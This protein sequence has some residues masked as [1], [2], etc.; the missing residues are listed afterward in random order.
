MVAEYA[1]KQ[2]LSLLVAQLICSRLF[3]YLPEHS[4]LFQTFH[5]WILEVKMRCNSNI[6]RRIQWT[7]RRGFDIGVVSMVVNAVPL[8]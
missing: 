1:N 8:K 4:R 3:Q 2:A 7:V 6:I 5:N